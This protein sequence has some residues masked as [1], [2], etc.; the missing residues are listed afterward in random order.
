MDHPEVLILG[1]R[2]SVPISSPDCAEFGGA[3]T[4]V[5]LRMN[6]EYIILDAGTGILRL[7]PDALEQPRLSLLLTHLHLDHLCGFSMC[8]FV[9]RCGKTLDIYGSPS[10]GESVE[11]V[12][13]ELYSPPVW[14]VTPNQLPATFRY[15]ALPDELQIGTVSVSSM[16]GAHPGGVK[17]LRLSGG[18]KTLVFATDFT[19]TDALY[20]KAVEFAQDCDLLLCDGQYSAEE[21][22]SRSCFGHNSWLS[23]AR[24][25]R[26]CHAAAVRIIHHDPSHTD[27]VLNS[28]EKE[29][30]AVYPACRMAR[31][32]E[33]IAL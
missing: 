5:L 1:A 28:A 27:E 4:C 10:G 13:S 25:G 23:A 14:P 9:L 24:L 12:L 8:P 11:S 15:H 29:A 33:V 3:T 26:D 31:E 18:G 20:P 16:E 22:L 19:L 7:P 21:Y 17:L 2:G 32:G 30:A 6:G